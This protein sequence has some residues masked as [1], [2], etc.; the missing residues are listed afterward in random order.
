LWSSTPYSSNAYIRYLY[1]DN[2][3]VHRND[4]DQVYGLSV[5]CVKD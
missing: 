3:K 1:W 4:Y 5:R 2:S